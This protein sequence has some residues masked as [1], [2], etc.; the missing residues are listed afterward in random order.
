MRQIPWASAIVLLT[1]GCSTVIETRVEHELTEAGVPAR[2]ASCMAAQWSDKLSID[3]IRGIGRFAAEVRAERETLT[4]GRLVQ[5]VRDW[6]DPQALG[7][8]TSS[9]ASCA[10]E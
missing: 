1:A 3:Q 2:M 5:H 9:A 7:V 8:V 10:F 6:N 4:I